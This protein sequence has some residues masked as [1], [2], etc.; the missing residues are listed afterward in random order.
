MFPGCVGLMRETTGF[1]V[2][3]DPDEAEKIQLLKQKISS[4]AAAMP[5]LLSR[6]KEY[7]ARI[8]KLDSSTGIIH[9]AF[10]KKRTG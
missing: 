4:N 3:D 6:M 8:D 2:M 9:P 1:Q 7:M 5:A 10:N